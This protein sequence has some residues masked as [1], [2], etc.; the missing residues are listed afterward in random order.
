MFSVHFSS[1]FICNFILFSRFLDHLY[2]HYSDFFFSHRLPISSSLVWFGGFLSC[3]F[4]CWIFLSLFILFSLLCWD[5][6]SAGWRV[7]VPLNYRI[8]SQWV[9]LDQWLMKVSWLGEL[10]SVFLWMELDLISLESNVVSSSEF[11]GV[12]GFCVALSSLS[13]ILFIFLLVGG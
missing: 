4:T 1:L 9:G 11:W 2:D 10:V 13:F 3:F 5:L 7:I 8:Y 12:Y 6:L